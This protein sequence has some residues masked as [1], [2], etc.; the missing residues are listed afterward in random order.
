MAKLSYIAATLVFLFPLTCTWAQ[1]AINPKIL[2][3]L[4]ERGENNSFKNQNITIYQPNDPAWQR[5]ENGLRLNVS[6][7]NAETIGIVL[8]GVLPEGC[9]L[10]VTSAEG[11]AQQVSA[12]D[13]NNGLTMLQISGPAAIIQA[14]P[15]DVCGV[16]MPSTVIVD[17]S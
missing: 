10:T 15:G 6:T 12:N 13:A 11:A 5:T 16:S 4:T 14:S 17:G 8:V 7:E 9:L 2:Q 1:A 3:G